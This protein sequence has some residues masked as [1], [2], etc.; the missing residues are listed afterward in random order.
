MT[1]P[2]VPGDA[3]GTIKS[4]QKPL[5]ASPGEVLKFHNR[6]DLDS[7]SFAQ[8]HTLGVKA[9]QAASGSHNHDG[10][11]SR[12]IG[13]GLNIVITGSRGGNAALASLLAALA[14]VMDFTDSTTA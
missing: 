12:K 5:G 6:S 14:K 4:D 11:G 10:Q 3:F 1:N 7:S 9:T 8:H 2:V 13:A